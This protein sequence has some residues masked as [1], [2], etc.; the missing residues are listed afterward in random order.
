MVDAIR[1]TSCAWLVGGFCPF[2][3]GG[4]LCV[5]AI[6]TETLKQH[7]QHQAPKNRLFPVLAQ[8]DLDRQ[9]KKARQA[10]K[11]KHKQVRLEQF[12]QQPWPLSRLVF[13]YYGLSTVVNNYHTYM[14]HEDIAGS[15][16]VDGDALGLDGAAGVAP[17][18]RLGLPCRAV[19]PEQQQQE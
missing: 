19:A 17:R 10:S 7:K 18:R 12:V 16:S 5:R 15:I 14:Y 1:S 4:I 3:G 9:Q 8:S 2:Y 6:F 11:A 13:N